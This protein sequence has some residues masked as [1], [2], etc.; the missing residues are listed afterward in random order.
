MGAAV[1]RDCGGGRSTG[2]PTERELAL[3]ETS[4][5]LM[6]A[7]MPGPAPGFIGSLPGHMLNRPPVVNIP[8]MVDGPFVVNGPPAGPWQAPLMMYWG[9]PPPLPPSPSYS[10]LPSWPSM[11]TQESARPATQEDKNKIRAL[12]DDLHLK[13]NSYAELGH[14]YR[15]LY[16]LFVLPAIVTTTIVSVASA[17]WPEKE[18]TWQRKVFV[19]VL[20]AVS[21]TLTSVASLMKYQ[22]KMDMFLSSATQMDALIAKAR[23]IFE[24]QR[25]NDVTNERVTKFIRE[26][27]KKVIDIRANAPPETWPSLPGQAAKFFR[28]AFQMMMPPPAAPHSVSYDPSSPGSMMRT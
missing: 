10:P 19:S 4:P 27:E 21:A 15:N 12:Y 6:A 17:C 7:S 22:S 13:R 5:S 2:R 9:S 20:S 14:Y 23:F 18:Y 24:W 26:A 3:Y 16:Y 11:D 8:P 25:D 1:Y 28:P